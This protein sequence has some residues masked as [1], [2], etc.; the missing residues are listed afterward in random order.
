M[1]EPISAAAAKAV[2]SA[3]VSQVEKLARPT[4]NRRLVQRI[5]ERL[6]GCPRPTWLER[7]RLRR[8]FKARDTWTALL[9][10][11]VDAGANLI[12]AVDQTLSPGPRQVMDLS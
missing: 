8:L 3:F 1:T 9:D 6:E 11:D 12:V 2:A 4:Y 10:A 7:R 5:A